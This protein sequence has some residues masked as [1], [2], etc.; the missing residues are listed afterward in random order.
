VISNSTRSYDDEATIDTRLVGGSTPESTPAMRSRAPSLLHTIRSNYMLVVVWAVMT[1]LYAIVAPSFWSVSILQS[2]FSSQTV[3]LAL[4][5]ASLC[6][7]VV[8]EFD[9]SFASVMGLSTTT[10]LV[11]AGTHG[12]NMGLACFIAVLVAL[13][14]GVVNAFFVVRLE[15]PSLVVTLG[16][17]SL[18]LGL[19]QFISSSSIVSIQ[20]PDFS[21]YALYPILGLPVAFYYTLALAAAFAYVMAWTPLGRHMVFTGANREVARL[22]GVN[23]QR[24][25]A[26]GYVAGAFV[27]GLDGILLVATVG[28]FDPT[29]AP[30]FLLPALAAVF[31]GTA[32]VQPG[33]F[34]AMG[35]VIA[36]YFLATGIIGLQLLGYTGW[37]QDA[38]YGGGLVL[39][40]TVATVVRTRAHR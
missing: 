39:A 34:N 9:L 18:Y 4:G 38:F 24:I 11:L 37:V 29:S 30:T 31:L 14:C 12:M 10:V 35:T 23:V 26:G 32:V 33:Q 25:R 13:A 3:L 2:I 15:V 27:A 7:F 40:V 22:A 1:A 8:G 19:A 5:V 16:S 36:I 21:R 28:G 17:A 6:T 20:N